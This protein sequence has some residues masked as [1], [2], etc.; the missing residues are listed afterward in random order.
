MLLTYTT[1]PPGGWL[2]NQVDA[3]GG[4]IKQFRSMSSFLNAVEEILKF[5]KSNRLSRATLE[6]CASDLEEST[7]ARLGGDGRFCLKKKP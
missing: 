1:V 5:R 3:S 7:C 2:Y 4:T 6:E